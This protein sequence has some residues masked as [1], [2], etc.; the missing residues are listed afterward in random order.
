MNGTGPLTVNQR[1]QS[2]GKGGNIAQSE[3]KESEKLKYQIGE[4][5]TAN[6]ELIQERRNLMEMIENLEV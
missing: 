1:S 6:N 2:K 3:Q 5:Q 4:M